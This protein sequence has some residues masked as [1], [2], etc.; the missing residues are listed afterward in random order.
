MKA[1]IELFV[2]VGRP[3]AQVGNRGEVLV[4]MR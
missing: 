2:V 3:G 4:R 1:D